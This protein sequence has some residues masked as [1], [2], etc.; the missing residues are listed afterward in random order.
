[1]QG[2]ERHAGAARRVRVATPPW[3][4]G[5]GGM[6]M[7]PAL[8]LAGRGPRPAP[9]ASMP[10]HSGPV[11]D[12]AHGRAGQPRRVERGTAV[13]GPGALPGMMCSGFSGLADGRNARVVSC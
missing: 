9:R 1:M 10:A 12:A 7:Q 2:G 8:R 5:R 11:A 4:P 13:A 3:S 6:P